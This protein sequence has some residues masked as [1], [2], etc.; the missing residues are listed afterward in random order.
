MVMWK[1]LKLPSDMTAKV[2]W[3]GENEM[4]IYIDNL[5]KKVLD[6]SDSAK[7]SA[8]VLEWDVDDCKEDPDLESSCI[9]GKEN[10]RYLFT[11]RNKVNGNLLYPIGSTCIKKFERVELNDVVSINESLFKLMHAIE[12]GEFI[13]LSSEFFSRKLLSYLYD[14]EV[15]RPSEYNNQSP[16]K[17]YEFLLKM[18]NK[19][20][21][22]KITTKQQS[23][24]RA[25]IMSSIRPYLE[26]LLKDKIIH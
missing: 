12:N 8:A 4:S 13:T 7:W 2:I 17:D 24:I 23:K 1:N 26:R 20:S 5:I 21:K 6:S 11:I 19:K 18:F 10:L 3:R 25:I 22:D 15:F 16:E 14:S 9:C